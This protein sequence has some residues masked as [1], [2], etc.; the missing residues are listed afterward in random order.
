MTRIFLVLIALLAFVGS[1]VMAESPK[2][3]AVDKKDVAQSKKE[4]K[5]TR[6]SLERLASLVDRWHEANLEGNEKDIHRYEQAIINT[7]IKDINASFHQADKAGRE[8]EHARVQVSVDD[9][10]DLAQA[11]MIL[12]KKQALLYK[13]KKS[14]CFSLRYRV[15]NDYQDLLRRELRI[16]RIELAEDVK[17][18]RSDGK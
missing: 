4:L 1:A 18:V 2:Q 7:L 12:A 3:Q 17:D 15:L 11:R 16:N 8:K 6:E 9:E 5:Q 14:D 10:R 13:L